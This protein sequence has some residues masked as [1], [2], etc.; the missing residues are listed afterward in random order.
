MSK[1]SLFRSFVNLSTKDKKK[2]HNPNKVRTFV[3]LT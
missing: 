2:L 3:P 1:K